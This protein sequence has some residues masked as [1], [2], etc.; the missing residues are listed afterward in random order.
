MSFCLFVVFVVFGFGAYLAVFLRKGAWGG[1]E[2]ERAQSEDHKA[3][4]TSVQIHTQMTS[5]SDED[6][7]MISSCQIWI[8]RGNGDVSRT[9]PSTRWFK[10]SVFDAKSLWQGLKYDHLPQ[11]T[12][13]QCH[14]DKLQPRGPP[15]RAQC[16]CSWTRSLWEDTWRPQ[17]AVEQHRV[18]SVREIFCLRRM[19]TSNKLVAGYMCIDRH[20]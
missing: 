18:G 15:D 5:P 9:A 6:W 13:R 3:N 4:K 2:K 16:F 7:R 20:K 19:G 11:Q 8:E 1:R 12:A 17:H 14:L 10:F